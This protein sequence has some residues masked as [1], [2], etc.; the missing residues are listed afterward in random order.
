[1][2]IP[3]QIRNPHSIGACLFTLL[4]V[5]GGCTHPDITKKSALRPSRTIPV[6]WDGPDLREGRP[7]A[8]DIT[9]QRGSVWIEVDE[10]LDE[11]VIEG[12]LSWKHGDRTMDWPGGRS[13]TGAQIDA[14]RQISDGHGDVL[15]IEGVLEEGAPRTAFLDLRVRTPRC[16]GVT[17]INDDGPI[18][19]VG[20][21][22]AI[23]AQNGVV[24]GRG[25]RI[26]LRTSRA[27]ADPVALITTNGR[28][29]VVLGPEAQGLIELDAEGGTARFESEFGS[30]T[31][32]RP[33]PGRFRGVW[34]DGDNPIIARSAT[35]PVHVQV[36]HNAEM[37]SVADDWLALIGR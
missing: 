17:V 15:M 36:Q 19:L 4:L 35:G 12:V 37:Y 32:V 5:L 20:V 27:I 6:N 28:I 9:N 34:N 29:S 21:G 10:K 18:V 2:H 7:L 3:N 30:V 22:G 24:G 26:E 1:M 8:I 23:T 33:S 25:G 31:Q 11:P 14:V 13:G 16:D